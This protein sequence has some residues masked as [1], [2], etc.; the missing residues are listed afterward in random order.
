M[1]WFSRLFVRNKASDT[2]PATPPPPVARDEPPPDFAYPLVAVSGASAVKEWRRLNAE[3]RTE[4]ASAVLLGD[5]AEVEQLTKNQTLNEATPAMI[6]ENAAKISA[7]T[8]FEQRLQE[9]T[10]D[11]S[12]PDA[13]DWPPEPVSGH[14]LCAHTHISNQEPKTTVYLAKIPTA[15]SWEIPAFL[16]YGGWNDCPAAEQQV[17]VL[18]VWSEKYGI[19]I[20][21][22]LGDIMECVAARSPENMDEALTLAREQFL[23]CTDIVNQGTETIELLAAS[24]KASPNWYFWWD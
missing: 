3:W 10:E 2:K 13:A 8:F 1:N 22:V 12:L 9:C 23:F 15:K 17:A 5:R 4:G 14:E 7:A 6:L 24:L 21:S 16:G 11:G 20:Y 19:E 18:K